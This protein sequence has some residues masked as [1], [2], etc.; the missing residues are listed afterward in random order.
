MQLRNA[1]LTDGSSPKVET[2]FKDMFLN[3]NA[4][5]NIGWGFSSELAPKRIKYLQQIIMFLNPKSHL[6]KKI[7]DF[8][9]V[10]DRVV[11]LYGIDVED[12]EN[13]PIFVAV[14]VDDYTIQFSEEIYFDYYD[15]APFV[16]EL[17]E[18]KDVI[19]V[20]NW[21]WFYNNNVLMTID[22]PAK[23]KRSM[24]D[25]VFTRLKIGYENTVVRMI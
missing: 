20:E 2:S 24:R 8:V 21:K 18:K 14:I 12:Y 9:N 15:N 1:F 11:S 16:I 3:L 22:N 10:G 4:I 5:D 13:H 23:K 17:R 19:R 6:L 25:N 7:S